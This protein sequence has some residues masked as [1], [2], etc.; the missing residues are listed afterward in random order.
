MLV[1][2]KLLFDSSSFW[3]LKIFW[4]IN[5]DQSIPTHRNNLNC[6]W[7]GPL[8]YSS[9]LYCN[10]AVPVSCPHVS[11]FL[12][13]QLLTPLDHKY[14]RGKPRNPLTTWKFFQKKKSVSYFFH[15]FPFSP[16]FLLFLLNSLWIPP[17]PF[18][19]TN[20]GGQANRPGT[21]TCFHP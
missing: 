21:A 16:T 4:T 1:L 10:T 9:P 6:Q 7:I 12:G 8:N 5:L 3:T 17:P 2:L 14:N 18:Q 11:Q 15:A 13:I 19:T 20:A